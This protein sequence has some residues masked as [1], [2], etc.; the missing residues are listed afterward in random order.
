MLE[1]D[2]FRGKEDNPKEGILWGCGK[3]FDRVVLS[4]CSRCMINQYC[5][6]ECQVTGWANHKSE[7]DEYVYYAHKHTN[8]VRNERD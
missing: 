7:C 2:A 5:S 1:E 6:R 3:E 4:V 8:T